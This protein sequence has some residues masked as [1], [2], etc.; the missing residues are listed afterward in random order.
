MSPKAP[1]QRP[2][3]PA[4]LVSKE[5]EER[6][7][8]HPAWGLVHTSRNSGLKSLFGSHLNHHHYI[9][10][11]IG[12]AEKVVTDN[13][14]E[15]YVGSIRGE[16]IEICL[17]ETQWGQLLSS[18]GMGNGIPCTINYLNREKVPDSP[19]TT[20]RQNFEEAVKTDLRTLGQE[21]IDLQK[22]VEA[23]LS[24]SKPL[25]KS[26]RA[27]LLRDLASATRM[28]TDKIPFVQNIMK[29]ALEQQVAAAKSE[30]DG[31]LQHKARTLGLSQIQNQVAMLSDGEVEAG[32]TEEKDIP[33]AHWDD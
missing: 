29:E 12:P 4:T 5:H 14:E 8:K 18:M 6:R 28:L 21:L 25:N 9:T 3:V 7:Y 27:E 16:I 15:R 31:F 22:K 33:P 19:D 26:E 10:L 30:I 11:S 23:R 1:K 24:D 32:E 13:G 20:F 2:E 17:S